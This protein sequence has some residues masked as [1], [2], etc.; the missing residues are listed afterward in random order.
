MTEK[1]KKATTPKKP[2]AT[3]SKEAA[4]KTPAPKEERQQKGM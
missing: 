4:P 2:R 3:A 1:I